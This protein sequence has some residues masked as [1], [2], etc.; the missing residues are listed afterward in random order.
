MGLSFFPKVNGVI[1]L[2]I[3]LHGLNFVFVLALHGM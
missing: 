2:G 1:L 3:G